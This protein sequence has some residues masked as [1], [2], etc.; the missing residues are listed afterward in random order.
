MTYGPARIGSAWQSR[1][2]GFESPQLHPHRK[3]VCFTVPQLHPPKTGVRQSGSSSI[4]QNR[5]DSDRQ[6]VSHAKD[7]LDD[8]RKHAG[9]RVPA[10]SSTG[11]RL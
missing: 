9:L 5:R 8:G 3:I 1:G 2:Q 6:P 4:L 10:G 7:R 11:H